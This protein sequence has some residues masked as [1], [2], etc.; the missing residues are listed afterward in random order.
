ME[1]ERRER[2]ARH[3]DLTALVDIVFHLMVFFMLTTSFVVSESM[4]LS[5]PS[6]SHS[7]TVSNLPQLTRIV[8]GQGGSITVG[9]APV[10]ADD[11]QS[12]LITT[13]GNNPDARIII[14]STPGV[15]VQEL[16]AVLDMVY[17]AG[18]RNVQVDKG[19]L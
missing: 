4:E 2:F 10:S 14:L 6:S 5:L 7:A 19:V 13:L 12:M 8:V 1:F 17:F 9:G 11:L 18:G 15:L 3:I 16:V